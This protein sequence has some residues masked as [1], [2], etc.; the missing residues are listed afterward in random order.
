MSKFFIFD[1]AESEKWQYLAETKKGR[2]EFFICCIVS[3]NL[4]EN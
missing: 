3:K 1:H 4:L 2:L